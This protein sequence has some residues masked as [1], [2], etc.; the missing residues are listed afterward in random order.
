MEK[1]PIP[2]PD[3]LAGLRRTPLDKIQPEQ[4]NQ[5]VRDVIKRGAIQAPVE[6][7]RFGSN[8]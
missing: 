8:I 7:A 6:V 2:L 3:A 4:A 5:I 1:N